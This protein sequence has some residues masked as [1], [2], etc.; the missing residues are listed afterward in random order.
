GVGSWSA[1]SGAKRGLAAPYRD[2]HDCVDLRQDHI[3]SELGLQSP[4]PLADLPIA[5]R[6]RRDPDPDAR[7][8]TCG[9]LHCERPRNHTLTLGGQPPSTK[10]ESPISPRLAPCYLS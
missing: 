10:T 9:T 5:R 4:G 3:K 8:M 1:P 2:R 6:S 7:I